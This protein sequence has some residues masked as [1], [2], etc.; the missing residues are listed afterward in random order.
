MTWSTKL[1]SLVYLVRVVIPSYLVYQY[2]DT[3]LQITCDHEPMIR[4][5]LGLSALSFVALYNRP[6]ILA[7]Q[8]ELLAVIVYTYFV[9]GC[10][11][12]RAW[13]YLKADGFITGVVVTGT[14]VKMLC[15]R[16]GNT[17]VDQSKPDINRVDGYGNVYLVEDV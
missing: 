11:N 14:A 1:L 2:H 7:Y 15:Y 10:D 3:Q 17:T 9:A 5:Y 4:L 6:A 12:N 16:K 13:Q 8:S